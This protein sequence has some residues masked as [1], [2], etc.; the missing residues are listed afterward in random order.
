MRW[1]LC[2][3]LALLCWLAVPAWGQSGDER[4]LAAR[5]AAS[6]GDTARLAQMMMTPSDHVLEPY[7]TYWWLATRIARQSEVVAPGDVHDFLRANEGSWLAEKLRADWLKRL[8]RDSQWAT[9]S[10]E[11]PRLAQPDQELQCD[12]L[13]ATSLGDPALLSALQ[14]QWLT[15]LDAPDACLTVMQAMVASGRMSDDDV[16]WRARRLIETRRLTAA[17]NT[18]AWARNEVVDSPALSAAFDNPIR[19]L[20]GPA[21]RNTG[22]AAARE[23]IL[24]AVARLA[25]SDVEA[26][27]SRWREVDTRNF[28]A[29]D[30][31][32][33][34]GQLGWL[35]ALAHDRRALGWFA[36]ANGIPLNADQQAWYVRAAL[37][38]GD[39]A[40]VRSTIE[41]L[42]AAQRDQPEWVYWYG[43]ALA[44]QGLTTDAQARYQR[45]AG[46]VDFFS[47]LATE[48]LGQRAAW[49][50]AALPASDQELAAVRAQPGVQRTLALL[51]LDLR[52][53]ALRE[54][55]WTLRGADDRHLLASAELM[56]Q[57]GYYDRA[58]AA[59]E[60]TRAQ[61]DFGLRYLAP[62]YDTFAPAARSSSLS[63]PWVYGLVRQESRFHPV[64]R[65]SAG[66]Q[67]LMQIMP[68]TGRYVAR[69]IGMADYQHSGLSEIDT[70]I[71]LGTAYL[72]M[73]LDSLGDQ[74][75][76]AAAAYNAGPARARRWRDDKP[77]E[78]AL[79]VET[80]PIVETRDYVEKVM[81]NAVSYAILF[82]GKPTS[83]TRSLGTILPAGA[84]EAKADSQP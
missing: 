51:Q 17:R 50:V 5:E 25:R 61:H 75:V 82:N 80:I 39:W 30:R 8:A 70:N 29:S 35:F 48:A 12:R 11:Y 76:L 18:L 1:S 28:S 26:A 71:Q 69:K 22:S 60:R 49:P 16:L 66:A 34:A 81:A 83:L 3:T 67:G 68:A 57:L 23:A 41:S 37:R 19:F 14:A 73:I 44:A 32:Y 55:S 4:I 6:R 78:G 9:F 62:Y 43:R 45:I 56:R 54:W 33:V 47:L 10:D 77:M 13:Q 59:A 79:Y 2:A 74:P 27:E 53:E 46:G 7:V 63:L 72:R 58:I 21:R 65:S 31:A 40:L 36:Q 15:L 64:V 38:A 24:A 42:P 20:A 52:T 84:T